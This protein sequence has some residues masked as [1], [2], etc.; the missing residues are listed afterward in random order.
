MT[1]LSTS[2]LRW[3]T[4]LNIM[5]TLVAF[6]VLTVCGLMFGTS[7]Q[8]QYKLKPGDSLAIEVLEDSSLNRTVL[9]LPDGN[10]SFPFAG[11]LRAQGRTLQAVENLIRTRLS[12]NFATEPTVFVNI[13]GLAESKSLDLQETPPYGIFMMGE[14]N[15]PGRLDIAEDEEITILQAL[16]QAGG[17]TRFAATKRI[18]LRRPTEGGEKTYLFNFKTG[19]GISG[20]TMLKAG[21]VIFVPERRLFE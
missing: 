20:A 10:I 15:S 12:G 1:S 14:V 5:Q 3:R 2:G 18:T 17:F 8:A 19:E 11:A 7:A 13:A 21:D 4:S 9:V 6:A 16:A